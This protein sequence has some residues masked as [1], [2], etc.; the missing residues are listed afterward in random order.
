MSKIHTPARLR[1][2]LVGRTISAV[3]EEHYDAVDEQPGYANGFELHLDDGSIAC[4]G[5]TSSE[6]VGLSFKPAPVMKSISSRAARGEYFI[7]GNPHNLD[8]FQI[9]ALTT[10]GR[11]SH[12]P[13]FKAA[14][15]P[16]MQQIV[17][18][19]NDAY[20]AGIL[21]G[22]RTREEPR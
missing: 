20:C 13:L 11:A 17:D 8:D 2:S 16:L 1:R 7:V 6:Q 4:F 15:L 5:G 14:D 3:F 19:L 9:Y 12:T 22:N 21:Q 18:A 10:G